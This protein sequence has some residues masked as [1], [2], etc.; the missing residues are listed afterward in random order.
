MSFEQYEKAVLVEISNNKLT[1]Y[2]TIKQLTD[3]MEFDQEELISFLRSKDVLHGLLY[4][5]INTICKDAAT[6]INKKI[7]IA[8]GDPPTRGR[9]GYVEYVSNSNSNSQKPDDTASDTETVDFKQVTTLD[10]VIK[11]QLVAVLV[12]PEAG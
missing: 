8:K 4:D 12:A 10:N 7:E 2:L 5:N 3:S 9:D 6:L 11:G 1:A